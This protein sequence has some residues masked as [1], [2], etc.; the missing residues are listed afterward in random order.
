MPASLDLLLPGLFMDLARLCLWL[1]ALCVIFVPL[2]RAFALHRQPVLRRQIAVDLGWYF[3]NG[4]LPGLVLGVPLSFVAWATHAVMPAALLADI[5]AWPLALRVAAALLL[6]ELGYYWA[7]RCA[8]TVPFLWG[9]HAIHH[10]A[11]QIDF[12]TNTR[13][14]PVDLMFT[15]MCS[16][17]PLFALGLAN[18]VHPSDGTIPVLVLLIGVLWGFFIHANLRLRFGPLEWLL[19]TPAFHHWHH[20]LSAPRD[21][22]Y[23]SMLPWLD[24]LFGSYHLPKGQWP[25]DYGNP[26]RTAPTL[27]GQ[28]L[29]PLV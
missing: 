12:L 15:R 3:I 9:F 26:D 23:A 5:A 29:Q 17:V 8:H 24:R 11:E 10:S 1:V 19:T 4:L 2:E 27:A 20:T 7:H 25:A 18:P 21:H 16:L 22:N 6:G 14:H 28:F 13:A